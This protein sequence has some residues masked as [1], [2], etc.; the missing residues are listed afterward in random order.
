M[1]SLLFTPGLCVFD[2]EPI[3]QFNLSVSQSSKSVNITVEPGTDVHVRL[4]YKNNPLDQ[5]LPPLITVRKV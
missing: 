2:L 1:R 5:E 3:P 4:S